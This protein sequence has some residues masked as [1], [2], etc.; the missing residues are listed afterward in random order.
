[1]V[2]EANLIWKCIVGQ[3]KALG[4]LHGVTG[5]EVGPLNC[6]GLSEVFGLSLDLATWERPMTLQR[7]L[8]ATGQKM[9]LICT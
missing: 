5:H 6:E 2:P 3:V 9:K 8:G 4:A 7:L 1:M